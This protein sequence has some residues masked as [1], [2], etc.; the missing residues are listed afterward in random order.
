VH[1]GLAPGVAPTDQI[2]GGVILLTA[3]PAN[4]LPCLP[5]RVLTLRTLRQR[6]RARLDPFFACLTKRFPVRGPI[7][8]TP[9]SLKRNPDQA[10]SARCHFC[11]VGCTRHAARAQFSQSV[12]RLPACGGLGCGRF[13]SSRHS[14]AAALV[15]NNDSCTEQTNPNIRRYSG[16]ASAQAGLRGNSTFAARCRLGSTVAMPAPKRAPYT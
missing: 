11:C 7:M 5:I 4:G 1:V 12:Q 16:V 13:L 2:I 15:A 9:K 6:S 14:R 10:K 3:I 8:T